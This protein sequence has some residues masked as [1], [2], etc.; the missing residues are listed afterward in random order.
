MNRKNE[1]IMKTD[2]RKTLLAAISLLMLTPSAA[3]NTKVPPGDTI[4][5]VLPLFD[6]V[7][8]EDSLVEP[9]P[10][11]RGIVIPGT[12]DMDDP[13][14]PFSTAQTNALRSG[15]TYKVGTPTTDSGVSPLGAATW[16]LTFEAPPGVG[17]LTP[18]VGLS[19]SSQA[20]N[21]NAGW[22]VSITGIS[23]I[24]RGMKTLYHDEAVRG[25]KNDAHDALFLD[26]RRLLLFVGTE[27]TTGAVYYPEGDPYTSV[28]V[29]SSNSYG[30]LSFEVTASDGMTH[31]YG[32]TA[33]ARLTFTDGGGVQR[34]HAWYVSRQEDAHGNYVTYSYLHDHL[35][36]YPE[37][38]AYGKNS[39]TGTGADNYIRFTYS[40]VYAGTLRS[41]VL[42]GVRGGVYKCLTDV[43]TMTGSVVYREYVLNYDPSSDGTT[44]KFERLTS[45]TCKNGVGEEMKPVT[46]EWNTMPGG[47]QQTTTLPYDW[48]CAHNGY[49]VKD[50][51]FIAADMDGNGLADIIR[52][53]KEM[54]ENDILYDFAYIYKALHGIDGQVTYG[55]PLVCSLGSNSGRRFFTHA[56]FSNFIADFDGDGMSDLVLPY[57]NMAHGPDNASF[58][59]V[60]G[61]DVRDGQSDYSYSYDVDLQTESHYMDFLT[62]DANNDGRDDILFIETEKAGDDNYLHILLS[63]GMSFTHTEIPLESLGNEFKPFLGDYNCDGLVDIIVI[64]DD[65]YKIFYNIGG[66]MLSSLFSNNHS[67]AGTSFGYNWRM[68]QGDFNGDGLVDFVYVG[69][70]SPDYYFALNNGDGTFSVSL[71]FDHYTIFDQVTANDN[72]RFTLT[73]MDIDRDGLTDLVVSK[74][75]YNHHGG[76]F[77]YDSFSRTMVGW[78]LSN[79][80]SL[81]EIRSIDSYGMEDEANP[82]N[83]MLADFDGDGWPELAN[84]GS[85]WYTN[86]T[87]TNDGCHVRIYHAADFTAA[88]GK[89]ARATDALGAYTA[90]TYGTTA[91][92]SLYTHDYATGTF[93]MADA[94]MPMALVGTMAKNDGMTGIHTTTYRYAGLKLHLQGKG[95]LGFMDIAARDDRTGVTTQNG[96]LAWNTDYYIPSSVYSVT[97]MGYDR[98]STATTF[99]VSPHTNARYTSFPSVK[100]TMDMDGNETTAAYTFHTAYGRMTKEH[101]EYGSP[102]MY[103]ETEYSLFE[104]KGGKW[105]PKSVTRRQKHVHDASVF[106][107]VTRYTYDAAGDPLT[108]TEHYGQGTVQLTTTYTRD[109]YGNVLS[110][111]PTGNNVPSITSYTVYDATGRFPVRRYQSVDSGENLFTY[112]TWGHPLT[113]TDAAEASNPLTTAYTLD[114]WG[115]PVGVTSPEGVVTTL[116]EGWA[117]NTSY[118]VEEQ[119]EGKAAVKTWYDCKGRVSRTLTKGHCNQDLDRQY[120]LNGWGGKQQVVNRTGTRAVIEMSSHDHR[121]RPSW[122]FRTGSGTTHYSYGN[123]SRTATHDGRAYDTTYDA[124][125]GILES[126]D[127]ACTVSYTYGSQGLPVEVETDGSS[128]TMAY[129]AAGRRTRLDDPDA[130]TSTT[131]YTADGRTLTHTDGRGVTTTNSYDALGRLSQS[132]SGTLTTAYTYGIAGHDRL[133]LKKVE[134]DGMSTEY[135]YDQYGRVVFDKRDNGDGFLSGHTYHYDAYGRLS[136][137]RFPSGLDEDYAYDANGC[138]SAITCNG[139]QVWGNVSDDG[140]TAVDGFGNTTLTTKRSQAG[141]LTESY[142]LKR[143][144]ETP[145]YRMAYT[146]DAVRGNLASRTGML[147]ATVTETFTY[148]DLDRLTGVSVSGQG[149]MAVEYGDGG[150]ILSKTGLGAYTY[151]SAHPHAVTGVENTGYV[152]QSAAQHID[153]NPW[154]KASRIE[155]GQYSQTLRYGPDRQRWKVVDSVGVQRTSRIYP[156]ANY[157]WRNENG[158]TRQFHYLENGILVLKENN[159]DFWYF[160]I[161]T[162]NV[163]SVVRVIDSEG[164]AVVEV[165]YDAWGKPTVAL[166]QMAFPR[167]FGGHEMLTKYRLVNMDGRLY[168]Y[169]LGRFL[170]PD[171]YVQEPS[172]SQ[173]FNRYTYCLNN[174]LKYTDPTGEFFGLDDLIMAA[175]NFVVS[176][177]SSGIQTHNWGWA[178]VQNG[179]VSAGMSIVTGGIGGFGG[180][181]SA[182]TWKRAGMIVANGVLGNVLPDMGM[183][184]SL[185]SHFSFYLSPTLA[186]STDGFNYGAYGSLNYFD[187]E[188]GF[189]LGFGSSKNYK[190]GFNASV[191]SGNFGLGYAMT[192]YNEQTLGNGAELGSQRVGTITGSYKDFSFA[193]SNDIIGDGK[194]RYRSNAVEI[195]YGDFSIGT[196][197]CTNDGMTE[198]GYTK[199]TWNIKKRELIKAK[200]SINDYPWENG[201]VLHSPIWLGFKRNGFVQRIGVN[202]PPAQQATQNLLHRIIKYPQYTQYW[203]NNTTPYNYIGTKNPLSIW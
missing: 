99:A 53:S 192:S 162:D 194:D 145:L 169:E 118:Y 31:R 202:Y 179:L 91:D 7:V 141:Q 127:P 144:Q 100:Y 157:E 189:S 81:T 49:S 117:S 46:L 95:A 71:A 55:Q 30:P 11:G 84:N 8:V 48:V 163:G 150:N 165:S 24:T 38:I 79:G 13:S 78:L 1:W 27:G 87:A 171:D 73:P 185:G 104:R 39:H 80:S 155:E 160:R 108:R 114:G 105:L 137:H 43:R 97:S 76:L 122:T 70:S 2:L 198:S 123:R 142:V 82:C 54:N 168:D 77:P 36:V 32:T 126:T 152:I 187:G 28:R 68:E 149:Q 92:P 136:R 4:R 132:V 64:H 200:K 125:G 170:S 119:T 103:R 83:I 112:D 153:Y 14:N 138:L 86:T 85:D 37:T 90:F 57:Y 120:T 72:S 50:S 94:H 172:N 3:A 19:Y 44:V 159:N 121:G 75:K 15:A 34:V 116:T 18:Q 131:T 115:D 161:L 156:H 109:S 201:K 6:P 17:G 40:G 196:Y 188:N 133:R 181:I 151:G 66:P 62:G 177:V 47:T 140:W 41:F 102:S 60:L 195:G 197:V 154:G 143:G 67:S 65:G 164:T 193:F 16:S 182:T 186:F 124:W 147:G 174:P 158:V 45:V 74:A 148:D 29:T 20:G 26:G 89:L 42:G 98:D 166:N 23:C 21:G 58:H 175:V 190:W 52:I 88:S 35:V 22:G 129:D 69:E 10:D 176:Y 106:Q 5:T 128:V 51:L 134:T 110:S 59:V 130:G 101:I 96:T 184:I 139:T 33:N 135:T 178:S 146:W 25:I 203:D 12:A 183:N 63:T 107:D 56:F 180:A 173:N 111:T 9:S 191:K 113:E 167:G 61:K 199:E 93:P